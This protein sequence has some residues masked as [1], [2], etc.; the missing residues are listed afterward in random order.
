[1]PNYPA[2]AALVTLA[3]SL[4]TYSNKSC[5]RDRKGSAIKVQF[6][7]DNGLK[8]DVTIPPAFC[9]SIPVFADSA[10]CALEVRLRVEVKEGLPSF[11]IQI[12]DTPKVVRAAFGEL[13]AIVKEEAGLPL[14][15]GTPE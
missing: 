13:A 14:F 5:K 15:I 4:E 2:P 11:E 1:M 6:T 9:I 10:P 3:E 7:E 8:S 12:H